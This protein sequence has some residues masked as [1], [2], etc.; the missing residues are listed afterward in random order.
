M[1]AQLFIAAITIEKW[2]L[3]NHKDTETLWCTCFFTTQL[4]SVFY[5]Y[6]PI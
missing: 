3:L 6:Q 5:F 4:K 2:I 1:V